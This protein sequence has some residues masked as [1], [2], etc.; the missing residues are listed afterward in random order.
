MTFSSEFKI[1]KMIKIFI[2]T[3]GTYSRVT[4]LL[5]FE[6]QHGKYY[7]VIGVS[8]MKKIVMRILGGVL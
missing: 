6:V 2:I 4:F 7:C 8:M 1:T 5:H 3:I